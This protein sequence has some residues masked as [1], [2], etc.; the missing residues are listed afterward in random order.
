MQQTNKQRSKKQQKLKLIPLSPS[1]LVIANALDK[2][3]Q[4][5]K[6]PPSQ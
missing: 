1:L 4:K 3:Q 5:L 6:T 2:Q